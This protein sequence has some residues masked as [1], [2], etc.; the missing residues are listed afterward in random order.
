M[1]G[2]RFLASVFL[3]LFAMS[4]IFTVPETA[5]AAGFTNSKPTIK[6]AQFL[7]NSVS[8]QWTKVTG[9]KS[10][11]IERRVMNP[12]T[13][14][15]ELFTVEPRDSEYSCYRFGLAYTA[16]GPDVEKNDFF[17]NIPGY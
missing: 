6:K 7:Y 17:E 14:K 3:V 10:Y 1:K 12:K 9:A 5:V 11:E 13:G 16:V 15:Y 8:L 4:L 2:K